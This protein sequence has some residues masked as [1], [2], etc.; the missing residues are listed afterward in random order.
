MPI[1][2]YT[3]AD[4]GHP[5]EILSRTF[6]VREA[7]CPQCNGLNTKRQLTVPIVRVGRSRD[8]EDAPIEYYADRG[9]FYSAS[10]EAERAGKSESDVKLIREGGEW[11]E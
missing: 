6:E 8:S 1:Y 5:F 7:P 9:D 11:R 3:C 4:C 2:P 10:I